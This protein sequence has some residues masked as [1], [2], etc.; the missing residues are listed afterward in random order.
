MRVLTLV[1]QPFAVGTLAL[2]AYNEAK[3]NSRKYN[4]FGY[5]LFFIGSLL[6]LVMS[7][8]GLLI[9]HSTATYVFINSNFKNS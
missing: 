7:I 8:V 5:V 6:V 1:Y 2:L 4:I 3:I 9:P